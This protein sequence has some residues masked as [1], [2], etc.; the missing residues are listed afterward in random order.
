MHSPILTSHTPHSSILTPHPTPSLPPPCPS[1]SSLRIPS[2][3]HEGKALL[4]W[5]KTLQLLQRQVRYVGKVVAMVPH[6]TELAQTFCRFGEDKATDGLL[7]AI[8]LGKKS[9]YSLQ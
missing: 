4:L 9:V 5:W 3:T 6:I 1:L 8:G 2:L 7:G